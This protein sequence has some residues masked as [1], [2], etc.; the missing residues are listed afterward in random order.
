[1]TDIQKYVQG[2][3]KRGWKPRVTP[4]QPLPPDFAERMR[5]EFTGQELDDFVRLVGEERRRGAEKA[6]PSQ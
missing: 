4:A 3:R 2:M 1:V 6:L 5:A